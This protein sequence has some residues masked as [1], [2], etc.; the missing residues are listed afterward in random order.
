MTDYMPCSTKDIDTMYQELL[1]LIQGVKNQYLHKLLE[2]FF[3]ED[4]E[5][6]EKFKKHSAAKSIHHGFIGGLLEHSLSVANYVNI[7]Q[8][9]IRLSI[10][11]YL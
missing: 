2:M 7:L 8:R 9:I 10:M 6:A 11:I 3:V 5:F 1:G 4:K